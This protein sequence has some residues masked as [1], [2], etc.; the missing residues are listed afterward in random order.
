VT[1]IDTPKLDKMKITFLNQN[2]FDCPRLAQF[3]NCTPTLR[4]R[5]G[6]LVRFDDRRT[7]VALLARSKTLEIS[8]SCAKPDRRLSSVA[9]V[10]NSFLPPF[11]GQGPLHRASTRIFATSLGE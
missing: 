4:A 3:I 5:D 2:D 9:Q 1:H 6:A 7:S 8:I 10:C 11:H